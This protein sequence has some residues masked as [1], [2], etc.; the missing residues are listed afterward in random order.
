MGQTTPEAEATHAPGG[1]WPG[2]ARVQ[3]AAVGASGE[4]L[5]PGS[6]DYR[7]LTGTRSGAGTRVCPDGMSIGPR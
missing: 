5:R 7:G 2:V 6:A 1:R 4:P 3:S